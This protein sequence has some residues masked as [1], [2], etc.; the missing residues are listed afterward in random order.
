MN[1][2]P[3]LNKN[4]IKKLKKLEVRERKQW[5]LAGKDDIL[6]KLVFSNKMKKIGYS[7]TLSL[8]EKVAYK[9]EKTSYTNKL[10]S[11]KNFKLLVR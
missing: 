8:Q 11:V 6:K 2:F 5:E 7:V 4:V 1:F 9:S 3:I 10:Q